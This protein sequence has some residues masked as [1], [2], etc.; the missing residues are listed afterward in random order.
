MK[1]TL[2]ILSLTS[3]NSMHEGNVHVMDVIMKGV[4][5]YK[6]DLHVQEMRLVC[7]DFINATR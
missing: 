2:R 5:R 4:E 1:G 3:V 6:P 7:N